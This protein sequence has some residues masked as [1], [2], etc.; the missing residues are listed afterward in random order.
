MN[1]FSNTLTL[2]QRPTSQQAR[3]A[4]LRAAMARAGNA[5][6]EALGFTTQAK[7]AVR[8]SPALEAAEAHELARAWER[9]DPRFAAELHAAA[10]RHEMQNAA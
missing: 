4:A 8:R 6:W 2:S 7:V 9:T 5:V 3:R 10:D 1:T